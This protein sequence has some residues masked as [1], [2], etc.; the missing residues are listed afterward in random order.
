[1]FERYTEKARRVIFFA[2]YEASQYGSPY[3][4]NEHLLL[5]LLREDRRLSRHFLPAGGTEAIRRKV[6]YVGQ[7]GAKVSTIVDLPLSGGSKRILAYAAQEAEL[8]THKHIG[9][10]HLF[11]GLLREEEGVAAA[12]LRE[13]G[14]TLAKAREQITALPPETRQGAPDNEI[15]LHGSGRD[16]TQIHSIVARCQRYPW[17]W[18]QEVWHPRDM[19]ASIATGEMSFDHSLTNDTANYKLVKNGWTG[20]NCLVCGWSLLESAAPAHGTGYTNG[21]DWLCIECYE[22]F[23]RDAKPGPPPLPEIT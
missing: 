7:T 16:A 8:L 1:M 23:F 14:V 20:D 15:L 2:R 19:V 17:L 12:V 5:G 18:R 21:R 10:E 13:F 4:E 3:I 11:L 22:K 9:T 6:D